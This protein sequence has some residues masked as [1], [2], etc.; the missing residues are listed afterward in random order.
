ML[1][2]RR[3]NSSR[4]TWSE[5]MVEGNIE[6]V[7][8]FSHMNLLFSRLV[9]LGKDRRG[10]SAI[11]FALSAPALIGAMGLA[12]EVSYWYSDNR[13]MQ[14][15]ADSAAIA[16]ATTGGANSVGEARAV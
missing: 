15:A 2:S 12:A 11:L 13:A 1:D 14:H 4:R 8:R 5:L 10:V 6:H 3:K 9:A 16:A 7:T